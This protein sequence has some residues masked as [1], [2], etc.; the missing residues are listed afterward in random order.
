MCS[1][2]FLPEWQDCR[3]FFA[4]ILRNWLSSEFS[5]SFFQA[6]QHP[7]LVTTPSNSGQAPS[8]ASA[9]AATVDGL[10]WDCSAEFDATVGQAVS[11]VEE[12]A[13]ISFPNWISRTGAMVSF[14]VSATQQNSFMSREDEGCFILRKSF[15]LRHITC[16]NANA[17]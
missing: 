7:H 3:I 9:L 12:D 13:F 1:K 8:A 2:V 14:D 16:P 10:T 6:S 5:L 4:P 17:A 11:F 15:Y